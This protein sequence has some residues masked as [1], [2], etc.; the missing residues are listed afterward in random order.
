M[1]SDDAHGFRPVEE[2]GTMTN[3][4]ARPKPVHRSMPTAPAYDLKAIG[5]LR[6]MPAAKEKIEKVIER[7]MFFRFKGGDLDNDPFLQRLS[8][9]N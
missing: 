4:T 7:S 1:K 5:A 9:L 8:R 3:I 2:L 6:R